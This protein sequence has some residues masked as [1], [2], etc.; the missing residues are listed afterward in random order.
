MSG[1]QDYFEM[2]ESTARWCLHKCCVGVVNCSVLSEKYLCAPT[3]SNARQIVK[4]HKT[5][6][7]IDGMMESLYI[8]KIKWE[9]CPQAWKGQFVGKEGYATICLEAVAD[10]DLWIWHSAFRFPAA[11]NDIN[12]WERS[13]LFQSMLDGLH[14]TIDFPFKINGDEFKELF[15]L[16]DGIYPWLSRFLSTVSD[17]TTNIDR[18]LAKS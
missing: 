18:L 8:T 13:A 5:V 9:K 6:H 2:G 14:A 16:V 15:Y 11:P 7:G 4:R 1:F 3:T 10:Y 17:P 12:I